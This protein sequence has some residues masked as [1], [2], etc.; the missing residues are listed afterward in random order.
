MRA[1]GRAA[2]RHDAIAVAGISGERR[3]HWSGREHA[4]RRR[5]ADY[6]WTVLGR[7]LSWGLDRGL[8]L[9]NPC[10]RGGRLYRGTR[11]EI[12]WSAADEA[13]FLERAPAQLHLPLL[14]AFA[15]LGRP[16]TARISGCGRERPARAASSR[17]APRS[18]PRSTPRR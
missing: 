11:R 2:K 18:K 13:L 7:T 14:L 15:C 5:Q 1:Q 10:E 3:F 12:V 8:V 9:A 16:M 6:A 17:S 4:P